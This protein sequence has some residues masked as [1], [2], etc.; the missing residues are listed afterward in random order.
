M[1]NPWYVWLTLMLTATFIAWAI[2]M[3][4]NGYVIG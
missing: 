4:C 3:K 1:Q 2:W